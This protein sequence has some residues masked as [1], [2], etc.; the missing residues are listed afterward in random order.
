MMKKNTSQLLLS[1]FTICIAGFLAS[2]SNELPN[3]FSDNEQTTEQSNVITIEE[4]QAHLETMLADI[5][6]AATRSGQALKPRKI[7]SSYST[8]SPITTRVIDHIEPYVHVFNFEDNEGFAIMSG[9]DRV[10]P[11]LAIAF[12]GKLPLDN[13]VENP[14]MVAFMANAEEYYINEITRKERDMDS[15]VPS[16]NRIVYGPWETI[17]Y[18]MP[19]GNCKVQWGQEAPYNVF[20]PLKDGVNTFTGCVATAVAQ[21]MSIYEHP[22]SYGGYSF[23]WKLMKMPGYPYPPGYVQIATLMQQ[24]GLEKNLDMNYGLRE[25]GG[26]GAS[27]KN[28]PR[29]LKNFGYS[30]GGVL[31][32]YNTDIV[33]NELKNGYH[34]LIGGAAIRTYY[35]KKIL[36]ITVSKGYKYSD[37]HQWLAHGLLERRRLVFTYNSNGQQ[38]SSKTESTWYPLCNFGW[39]GDEDGYY[40]SGVFDAGKGPSYNWSASTRTDEDDEETL[41]NEGTPK[42][43]QFKITTIVGIRK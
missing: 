40:L 7:A 3:N 1:L 20:C 13:G 29:T 33:V 27:P 35:K 19:D 42:N 16:G 38:I 34:I 5:Q 17:T 43:Y 26:S 21:L 30:S 31:T 10:D 9:D 24:L 41:Y 36:G 25:D 6:A 11:V 18:G 37:G 4:A 2:C 12:N 8:G 23:T 28:I 39:N 32:D 22:A 15:A 14:G